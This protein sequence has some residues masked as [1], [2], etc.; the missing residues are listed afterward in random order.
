MFNFMYD[1]T[2]NDLQN[3]E[4]FLIDIYSN[5]LNTKI[6]SFSKLT[7]EIKKSTIKTS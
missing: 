6:I 1:V 5:I 7:A 2:N 4:R 3:F